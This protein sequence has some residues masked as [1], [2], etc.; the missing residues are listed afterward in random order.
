MLF[1]LIL[2][3]S[4]FGEI[5]LNPHTRKLYWNDAFLLY[6]AA[7]DPYHFRNKESRKEVLMVSVMVWMS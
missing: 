1:N 4:T 7:R 2:I 3:S 5:M 6:K